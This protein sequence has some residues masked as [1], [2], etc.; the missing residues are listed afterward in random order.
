MRNTATILGNAASS[1]IISDAGRNDLKRRPHAG[2]TTRRRREVAQ[3]LQRLPADDRLRKPRPVPRSTPLS[4]EVRELQASVSP[5]PF[6]VDPGV[7]P[8]ATASQCRVLQT[9]IRHHRVDVKSPTGSEHTAPRRGYFFFF[10]ATLRFAGAFFFAA[11]FA[12][13]AFFTILPSWPKPSGGVAS[14]PARIAGTASRL[15]Q[16]ERKKNVSHQG[17][18]YGAS[19]RAPTGRRIACRADISSRVLTRAAA[20]RLRICK[21]AK[22]P[23]KWPFL[24]CA[25][26]DALGRASPLHSVPTGR[27]AR[28]RGV[29]N[30]GFAP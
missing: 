25:N 2:K 26:F 22:T 29:G 18:V 11:V 6:V 27:V 21:I 9:C 13:V 23:V 19:S 4:L 14:A 3:I 8:S 24:W 16:A 7:A 5:T 28:K 30:T 1:S 15:L 12:F 10:A 20:S 17:N